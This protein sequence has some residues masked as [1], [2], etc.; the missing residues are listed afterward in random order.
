[1]AILV[2]DSTTESVLETLSCTLANSPAEKSGVGPLVLRHRDV[3]QCRI[4]IF[5][6]NII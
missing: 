6:G 5:L 1:M 4:K 3:F 2:G